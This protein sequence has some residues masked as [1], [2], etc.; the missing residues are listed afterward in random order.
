[1]HKQNAV[2]T[3]STPARTWWAR[4]RTERHIQSGTRRAQS[5]CLWDGA[6]CILRFPHGRVYRSL[7]LPT[8]TRC[9]RLSVQG[10]ERHDCQVPLVWPADQPGLSPEGF[11][12]KTKLVSTSQF[13]CFIRKTRYSPQYYSER[14]VNV[15]SKFGFT[16]AWE[17]CILVRVSRV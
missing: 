3:M 5:V 2:L 9:P 15:G 10:S 14:W 7:H 13:Y 11:Y 12:Q 1:M 6:R 8:S 4:V 16:L 17:G